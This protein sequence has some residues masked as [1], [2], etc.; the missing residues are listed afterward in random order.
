M[1]I[2]LPF[3]LAR[4]FVSD[5]RDLIA[6]GWVLA[7]A[8]TIVP[9]GHYFARQDGAAW[10]TLA[11]SASAVLRGRTIGDTAHPMLSRRR[12]SVDSAL[13]KIAIVL[14]PWT[15]LFMYDAAG[16]ASE[17]ALAASEGNLSLLLRSDDMVALVSNVAGAAVTALAILFCVQVG[18]D[19]G[20][21]A[22]HPPGGRVRAWIAGGIVTVSGCIFAGLIGSPKVQAVLPIVAAVGSAFLLGGQLLVSSMITLRMQ[23]LLQLKAAGRRDEKPYAP[24]VFQPFLTLVGPGIGLWLL[25]GMLAL[26]GRPFSFADAYVVAIHVV[27]WAGII[28]PRPSPIAVQCILHEALPMGG[29]DKAAA[30]VAE[31]FDRPPEGALRLNPLTLKRTR[32]IH[33]WL[34]PVRSARIDKF[35]NPIR[36]LWARPP[37]PLPT[38]VL[39]DAAF[40]PDPATGIDQHERITLYLR[41]QQDVSTMNAS[42]AQTKKIVVIKAYPRP[43]E[44]RR[45]GLATY[46]WEEGV[47]EV[48]VQHVAAD[49]EKLYLEDGSILIVSVEGYVHA[50]EIEIGAPLVAAAEYETF[51]MPQ[52]ED[53]APAGG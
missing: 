21:T 10:M 50:Y 17:L 41:G 7:C 3:A 12:S 30:E 32:S 34:V 23:D 28:W 44:S 29:A 24:P 42:N 19:E 46:K 48:C 15:L 33:P 45:A 31:G 25:Q 8:Q 51:R 36:P 20:A 13:Q 38:H 1:R 35:D 47:P 5:N 49:T 37:A 39:G 22:W 43:G 2:L 16:L 27:I 18:H 40:E 14:T 9:L 53:Y 11:V 4:K 26:F 6:L 52:M